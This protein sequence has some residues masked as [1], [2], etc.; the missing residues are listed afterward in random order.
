[1]IAKEI[2]M[3]CEFMNVVM[4]NRK[5][6]KRTLSGKRWYFTGKSKAECIRKAKNN[7]RYNS[8]YKCTFENI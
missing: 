7:H 1:M 6:I 4:S 5:I 3:T 8:Q 2:E